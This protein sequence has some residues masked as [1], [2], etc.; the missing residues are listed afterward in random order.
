MQWLKDNDTTF[1]GLVSP[2]ADP[3]EW[4]RFVLDDLGRWRRRVRRCFSQVSYKAFLLV[5]D[6][7]GDDP[8]RQYLDTKADEQLASTL[9]SRLGAPGTAVLGEHDNLSVVEYAAMYPFGCG[10]CTLRFKDRSQYKQ[11]RRYVHKIAADVRWVALGDTCQCCSTC[12]HSRPR[13]VKHLRRSVP[14]R[15]ACL[16]SGVWA[17]DEE[18]NVLE[19]AD[20]AARRLR[21]ASGGW[22]E[23]DHLPAM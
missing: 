5:R 1:D 8:L 2:H 14:C 3:L 23:T 6:A 11:H 20:K 12:F 4:G 21:R 10:L 22:L 9:L 13:L 7:Y 17:T 18:L 19:E 16:R 15:E